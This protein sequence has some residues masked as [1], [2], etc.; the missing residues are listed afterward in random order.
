MTEKEYFLAVEHNKYED[1]LSARKLFNYFNDV[2]PKDNHLSNS[3]SFNLK[4]I[5]LFL[6]TSVFNPFVFTE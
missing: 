1:C 4:N 5:C 3:F 6:A 2:K